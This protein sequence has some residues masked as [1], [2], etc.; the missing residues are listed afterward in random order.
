MSTDISQDDLGSMLLAT[1]RYSLN[2]SGAAYTAE[3]TGR[4]VRR[5]FASIDDYEKRQVVTAIE[6]AVEL[7]KTLP[8]ELEEWRA[9]VEE[10]R[11][12]KAPFTIDYRCGKCGSSGLKLWRGVHG[13]KSKDGHELLCAA[14]LA[15][16]LVVDEKGKAREPGRR[17]VY[18]DQVGGWLPAVPVGD[19]YWGYTSVPT[20]D[21]RWWT[22]LPTYAPTP[23]SGTPHEDQGR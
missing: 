9:L 22:A 6:I 19:T 10:I 7:G 4:L 17:G 5:H 12:P 1:V 13:C 3:Y 2:G 8:H 16:G 15:P 21:V 23:Q 20:A 11:P 18:S 14:C